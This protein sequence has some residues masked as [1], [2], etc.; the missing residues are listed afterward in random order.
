MSAAQRRRSSGAGASLTGRVSGSSETAVAFLARR[1]QPSLFYTSRLRGVLV[2]H[3]F[4]EKIAAQHPH[5]KDDPRSIS[6]APITCGVLIPGV[7]IMRLVR[8][9]SLV[10]SR[11]CRRKRTVGR[12]S[13]NPRRR[14]V[15]HPHPLPRSLVHVHSPIP[16]V[17]PS[18]RHVFG[19][20]H[21]LP[22]SLRRSVAPSLLPTMPSQ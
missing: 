21:P 7:W 16:S 6:I 12:L 3:V 4:A 17:A 19:L 22:S 9:P 1:Q 10:D 11:R 18:L 13:H 5:P 14:S 8:S 2:S 15:T 20:P